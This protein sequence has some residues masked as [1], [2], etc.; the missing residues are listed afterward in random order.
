MANTPAPAAG[1]APVMRGLHNLQTKRQLA[2]AIGLTACITVAF[3]ILV[4]NPKKEAYAEFYKTYDAQKSF[5][6]MKANGRFQSC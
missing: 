3:K 4:N 1:S 2:I 6:R 5:E